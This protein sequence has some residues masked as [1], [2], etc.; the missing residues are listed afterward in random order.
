MISFVLGVLY[1]RAELKANEFKV[2]NVDELE[3]IPSVVK[4]LR[5]FAQPKYRIAKDQPGSGNT[6]NIGAVGTVSELTNGTGPFAALGEE[7]FD[8]YWMFF[9]TSDRARAAELPRPP[10]NNLKTYLEYKKGPQK[11]QL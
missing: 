5:F 3:A 4:D 10:Y 1:S 9:L 7:V 6:K 8:D 2:H 11:G